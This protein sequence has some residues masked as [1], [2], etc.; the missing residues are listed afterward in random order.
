M[1]GDTDVSADCRRVVDMGAVELV[2]EY[3]G[4]VVCFEGVC[5]GRVAAAVGEGEEGGQNAEEEVV[6]VHLDSGWEVLESKMVDEGTGTR[7]WSGGL[8]WG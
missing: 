6:D 5:W 3:E 4:L 1:A 2:A 8:S 7:R